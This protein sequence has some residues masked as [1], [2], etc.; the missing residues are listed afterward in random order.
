MTDKFRTQNFDERIGQLNQYL[1]VYKIF[2][3]FLAK[4]LQ[5]L[6]FKTFAFNKNLI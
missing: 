6:I 1:T 2:T 5:L 4:F 3:N